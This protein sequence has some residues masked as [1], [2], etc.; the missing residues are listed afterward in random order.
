MAMLNMRMKKANSEIEKIK[1]KMLS[2][3]PIINKKTAWAK[4]ANSIGNLLSNRETSH[5]EIGSP[6]NE[7]IGIVKSNDPNSASLMFKT[8]F[9]VG[10][11]DVHVEKQ[12]PD[13]KKNALKATRCLVL[14]SMDFCHLIRA[15]TDF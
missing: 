9:R 3:M 13:K 7:L 4:K 12:R 10:I 14:V 11:R 2:E 5:P 6:I 1:N 15:G 8:A